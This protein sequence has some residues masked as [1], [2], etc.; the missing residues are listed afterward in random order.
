VQNIIDLTTSS[1]Y[2]LERTVSIAQL[3][4]DRADPN[5]PPA[6]RAARDAAIDERAQTIA[7]GL[8][9]YVF[10]SALID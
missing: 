5:V 8:A 6:Q 9:A 7:T 2:I 4:I 1:P 3:F 10:P